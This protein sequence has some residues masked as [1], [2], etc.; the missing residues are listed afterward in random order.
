MIRDYTIF[1]E[2]PADQARRTV[3]FLLPG[4]T[5]LIAGDPVPSESE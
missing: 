4:D 2:E 5:S 3:G 1:R